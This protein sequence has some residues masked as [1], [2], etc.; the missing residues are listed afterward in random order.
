MN[1]MGAKHIETISNET[2]TTKMN[3]PKFNLDAHAYWLLC[4]GQQVEVDGQ[5]I[6]LT[7]VEEAKKTINLNTD[8]WGVLNDGSQRFKDTV[9]KWINDNRDLC[10]ESTQKWYYGIGKS[11]IVSSGPKECIFTHIL[12]IDEFCALAYPEANE[13][14]INLIGKWVRSTIDEK[15]TPL[16]RW[17]QVIDES[18]EDI[19]IEDL[20]EVYRWDKDF[21][22]RRKNFDLAN[23]LDYN[24]ETLV[25]K[26]WNGN[27]IESIYFDESNRPFYKVK[28]DNKTDILCKIITPSD[29]TDTPPVKSLKYEDCFERVKPKFWV[30]VDLVISQNNSAFYDNV[31]T[32]RQAKQLAATIKL[33][34]IM[35]DANFGE[36]IPSEGEKIWSHYFERETNVIGSCDYE[37]T[38][39]SP[40]YFRDK[41]TAKRAYE[42]NK[43]IFHDYFGTNE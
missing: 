19:Y 21:V 20:Y 14:G 7:I 39:P 10:L 22:N 1:A 4:E 11:N 27:K 37:Y 35:H 2:K 9:I 15:D 8:S 3:K 13:K 12:T 40:I 28:G 26:Y 6:Q 23:P 18:D 43:E 5:K 32:E 33:M 17:F 41:E 34:T 31:P 38:A 24:P 36:W 16:N 25:G 30:D 29:V 42:A